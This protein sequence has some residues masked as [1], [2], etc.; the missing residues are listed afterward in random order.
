MDTIQSKRCAR[1]GETKSH[2]FF[3]KDTRSKDGLQRKCKTCHSVLAKEWW[4]EHGKEAYQKHKDQQHEWRKKN[5]ERYAA[6]Q[7][8]YHLCRKYGFDQAE[9]QQRIVDQGGKCA[10]CGDGGTELVVD[11]CHRDGKVR[12]LLCQPCN[13]MLGCANDSTERLQ[14]AIK[15]LEKH[16]EPR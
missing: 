2:E 8:R 9:F 6:R 14:F 11:H 13:K 4:A 10:C 5:P 16:N 7:R 15:Y 12:D 3:H 1:C